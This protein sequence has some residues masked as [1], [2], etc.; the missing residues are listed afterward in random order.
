MKNSYLKTKSSLRIWKNGFSCLS[1][2]VL[3]LLWSIKYS[4]AKSRDDGD[5][6]CRERMKGGDGTVVILPEI[7]FQL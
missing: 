5:S 3:G 1:F 7:S 4:K 2:N 6:G